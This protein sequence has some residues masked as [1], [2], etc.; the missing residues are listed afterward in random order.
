MFKH[1]RFT[2]YYKHNYGVGTKASQ[3]FCAKD[4]F[5]VMLK[6]ERERADRN[7]QIFALV[8][9]NTPHEETRES[10]NRLL[11]RSIIRRLRSIDEGGWIDKNNI[12]VILSGATLS[13]ANVFA[14]AIKDANA[15]TSPDLTYTTFIYPIHN[16][17]NPQNKNELYNFD[18]ETFDIRDFHPFQSCKIDQFPDFDNLN[19]STNDPTEW[20]GGAIQPLFVCKT[21]IWKRIMD[22]IGSL[23]G[24]ILLSPLFLI[25]SVFIKITS[26]G[27][28]LFKQERIGYGGRT[29][30]LIKFRTMKH[31]TN[32][33]NHREYLSELIHNSITTTYSQKP[34]NKLDDDPQIIPLGQ[35]LRK[36]CLDELPQLLNVFLGDMSLVGPRPPI[37]YEVDEY[38]NWHKE[39]LDVMPGMTGLW[40]VSGKNNLTFR[41]MV[42][43][44]IHYIKHMSFFFDLKIII[45]TPMAII[46]QI[47]NKSLSAKL[48]PKGVEQNA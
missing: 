9:F 37:Q 39:R 4:E 46:K 41:Q 22:I 40:Q 28:V 8:V 10:A 48:N 19:C 14:K 38:I 3:C 23:A 26:P 11:L 13:G 36:S 21:P 18:P 47:L 30:T 27:P 6:R 5:S 29:F 7:G 34:M 32:P 20:T 1:N 24:L 2:L 42:S 17:N 33:A 25:L 43:L 12:G 16:N 44:D 15:E 45:K 35:I 31:N